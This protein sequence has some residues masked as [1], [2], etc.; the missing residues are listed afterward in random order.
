MAMTKK[1]RA[2]V[3][4]LRQRLATVA[5]LRWTE[6]VGTDVPV[7]AWNGELSKGFLPCGDRVEV[8]CS[9]STYHAIGRTDKT[10]SHRAVALY[11]TRLLALKALRHNLELEFALRLARID[12]Q[13]ENEKLAVSGKDGE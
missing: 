9:S 11:S 4:E 7:P 2:E 8:A 5:A 6:P 3:E 10:N 13:I 1:E 12:A